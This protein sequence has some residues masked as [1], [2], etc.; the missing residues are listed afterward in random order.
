MGETAGL[1]DPGYSECA[2]E[3]VTTLKEK[4]VRVKPSSATR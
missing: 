3:E 2:D 1:R 4:A